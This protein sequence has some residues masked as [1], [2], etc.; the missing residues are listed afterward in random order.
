MRIAEGFGTRGGWEVHFHFSD[1]EAPVTVLGRPVRTA[2]TEGVGADPKEKARCDSPGLSRI[3]RRRLLAIA[4]HLALAQQQPVDGDL[5]FQRQRD[6]K[7]GMRCRSALVAVDVLLKYP[8]IA[9]ELSLGA[10]PPNLRETFGKLSL[11]SFNCGCG[12]WFRRP[13]LLADTP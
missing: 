10:I 2:V 12:H 3:R 1:T 5:L 9:R 13:F 8:E 4:P 6:E 7:V 11:E